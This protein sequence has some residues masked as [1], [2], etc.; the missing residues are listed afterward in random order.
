MSNFESQSLNN[1][2]AAENYLRQ[3]LGLNS[4]ISMVEDSSGTD[5]NGA[6][7]VIALH[8]KSYE[9]QG[10]TGTAGIYKVYQNG[11]VIEQE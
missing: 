10:G 5:A 11:K 6:Y 7:Y 3:K 2:S 8:S 4:D 9:S 1:I